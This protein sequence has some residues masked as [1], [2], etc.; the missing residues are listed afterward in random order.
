MS[1]TKDKFLKEQN[2]VRADYKQVAFLVVFNS[3]LNDFTFLHRWLRSSQGIG[4]GGFRSLALP[5]HHTEL[6]PLRLNSGSRS[7]KF[8]TDT[9]YFLSNLFHLSVNCPPGYFLNATDCRACAVDQYQDQEAQTS[10]VPCP[11]GK[12]TLGKVASKDCYG[13]LEVT[14]YLFYC[15]FYFLQD[16]N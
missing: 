10:C 1:V 9:I 14:I 3:H 2:V 12:S 4:Q 13:N 15:L 8:D 16:L 11:R 5:S 7:F 6:R